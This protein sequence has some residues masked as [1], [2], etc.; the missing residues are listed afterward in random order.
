MI[1]G[2]RICV[3]TEKY[4]CK[5]RIMKKKNILVLL[6]VSCCLLF[7]VTV[8]HA[9]DPC[10][11]NKCQT[12]LGEF[13]VTNPSTIITRIFSIVLG[14]SSF[15]ALLLLLIAGYNLIISNGN[16][17]KIAA[18]RET[19]TSA[20]LGLLFI[21]FAIVILEVIGVDILRIPGFGK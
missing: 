8:S 9:A 20:V 14:I 15:G 19:I 3:E 2:W 18:A 17:E 10:P 16:K 1:G 13:D 12:A 11:G 7:A 5:D 6:V 21:I 4:L